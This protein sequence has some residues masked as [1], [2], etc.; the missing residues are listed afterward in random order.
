M[1]IGSLFPDRRV[2][3]A[4][5][6]CF[7]MGIGSLTAK[8]L[9]LSVQADSAI[10]MNAD[11]G[12]ILF[13]K[14]AK[15][16]QDPASLTKIATA[17]YTLKVRGERLDKMIPAEHDS[18]ASISDAELRRS[19]YT[20][21]AHWLVPGTSHIGIKRG[22]E[23]SLKD[24]L[25]GMMVA[26]AGDASN[27]IAQYVGGSVP[28][29]ME[30]LNEYLQG[31]GCYGTTFKNPHGLHHPDHRTTAYDMAIL[32]REA[33]KNQTF[34]DIVKTVQYTRPQT[35][36]Q[37]PITLIQ[38]NRLLKRGKFYYSKAIG[39]KTGYTSAAQNT[40]VA[41]ARD[42]NRLLI[43]VLMKCSDRDE[44]FRDAIKLFETAFREKAIR[45]TL[46]P[47]GLQKAAL[48]VEGGAGPI[49]TCL[50]KDIT[51]DFFPA[52]EPK[53]KCLLS[54]DKVA[55]PVEKGQRV[56][57]LSF[58]D[59]N[60]RVL[61]TEPLFAFEKVGYSWY[62]RLKQFFGGGIFRTIIGVILS[63]LL[64]LSLLLMLRR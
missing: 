7:F 27:V 21:P 64:F 63:L 38:T 14:N 48:S 54:W 4:F 37:K 49:R 58:Q 56:G 22:E 45:R 5:L 24:L 50:E 25:Y 13:E 44:I 34:C 16:S 15:K 52:E 62:Y 9:E 32:T 42:K 18:V 46:L 59:Q 55:I 30:L 11:D 61:L 41:A 60:G 3:W 8:P 6:A 2:F 19:N 31:I 39:V 33:L 35:N 28:T 17:I 57:V 10:L 36:K 26:S 43:A 1:N 51:L 53:V 40:L 29:F 12:A 47:R 20:L 23:L